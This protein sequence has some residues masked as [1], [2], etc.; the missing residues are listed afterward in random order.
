MTNSEITALHKWVDCKVYTHPESKSAW[1]PSKIFHSSST[2]ASNGKP[3]HNEIAQGMDM[4]LD[5]SMAT[6]GEPLEK[7]NAEQVEP[8]DLQV[9]TCCNPWLSVRI[10]KH[11]NDIAQKQHSD[12][13]LNAKK[14]PPP[15]QD[16]WSTSAEFVWRYSR[17][18]SIWTSTFLYTVASSSSAQNV[19]V[20]LGAHTT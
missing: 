10:V 9:P 6:I 15:Q 8:L 20:L 14:Q 1:F 7:N 19:V 3:E 2:Q 12:L 4:P 5:L 18:S 13:P 17:R 16:L 11:E